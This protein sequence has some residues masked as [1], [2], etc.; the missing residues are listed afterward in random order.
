MCESVRMD[1]EFFGLSNRGYGLC[2]VHGVAFLSL[3]CFVFDIY[4]CKAGVHSC[5]ACAVEFVKLCVL[6]ACGDVSD[7]MRG[8]VIHVCIV[9][10]H[11]VQSMCNPL[12]K[13]RPL[14]SAVACRCVCV[15]LFVT[16]IVQTSCVCMYV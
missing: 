10:V 2:F 16:A 8:A 3:K 5:H 7:A 13:Q 6:F 9:S 12:L 15:C 1:S 4:V 14:C 11:K